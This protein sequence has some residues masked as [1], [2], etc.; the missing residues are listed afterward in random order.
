M[1][2]EFYKKVALWSGIIAIVILF[3]VVITGLPDD[4]LYSGI[5]YFRNVRTGALIIPWSLGEL[6]RAVLFDML[7]V[8][9]SIFIISLF[10]KR[11]SQKKGDTNSA[12][13]N[14][15]ILFCSI[16]LRVDSARCRTH[17]QSILSPM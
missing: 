6:L 11:D 9:G 10:L 15:G 13:V 12:I 3:A 4:S 5:G 14:L 1:E 16:C 17:L 8:A 7:W 2:E